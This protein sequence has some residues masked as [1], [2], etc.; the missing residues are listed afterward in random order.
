MQRIMSNLPT[1]Q[2]LYALLQ[3]LL[4][5]ANNY[6]QE[7]S[8]Q[9]TI[10]LGG[11]YGKQEVSIEVN[12][13]NYQGNVTKVVGKEFHTLLEEFTR[14]KSF[15]RAQDTLKLGAPIVDHEEESF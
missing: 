11:H 8:L 9:V 2:E 4:A 12:D 1:N 13:C 14:R 3:S 7:K 5:H 10:I 15:Q 6:S